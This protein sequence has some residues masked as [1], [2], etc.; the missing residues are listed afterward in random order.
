MY[1]NLLLI[2]DEKRMREILVDY[3]KRE[4]FTIFEADNGRAALE[5][6]ETNNIH[7]VI[8]DIMIP[9]I[10]GWAVC[11]RM[12][13]ESGVPIIM[14]TA[15]SDE[16][17]KLMGY[18]LGA[19]DYVTKPFSPKVLVAK[20]KMLLKR[21]EGNVVKENGLIL[22][23]DIEVNKLSRTVKIDNELIE[24]APKEFDLLVYL[25]ENKEMV[26]T[27]EN[28]LNHVWGYDY[29]GDL[30]TIDTHIKK[31]RSKLGDK[32]KHINT[33]NKVGYKFEVNK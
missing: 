6:F 32:A 2:E 27:R 5:L 7:L 1:R 9:E 22:C 18:E 14:L 30:R 13:K 29:F 12:R 23:A 33:M 26:L 3:F 28:I 8:L 21:A 10:D 16:E 24:L 25:I 11:K 19:D 15:R 20:S 17:D 4:N 31:L